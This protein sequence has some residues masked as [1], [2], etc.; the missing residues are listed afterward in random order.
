MLEADLGENVNIVLQTGGAFDWKDPRIDA[1]SCQRFLIQRGE[2]LLQEELALLNTTEPES[3]ADF[4]VWVRDNYPA[5]RYGLVLWNHGG[6]TIMGFGADQ[7]YPDDMMSLEEMGQALSE[8]GVPMDF[9][10][11]DACLM[12]TVETACML[13]PY[14]DYLIASEEMEPG[15]GWYYTDWLSLLGEN[16]GVSTEELGKKIVDDFVDGPDS[17]FWSD[18]T[19]SVIRLKEISRFYDI[20]CGYLEECRTELKTTGGYGRIA[21]ARSDT[22]SYGEGGFEQID[23]ADYVKLA[24]IEGGEEVLEGLSDIVAYNNSNIIGANGLAMYFPYDYPEYYQETM[25]SMEEIGIEGGGYQAF[26][27][28]F[29]NILVYGQETSESCPSVMA[30]ITGYEKEEDSGSGFLE[31][32][33]WY[34]PELGE[35]Y[36]DYQETLGADELYLEEKDGIFVLSLT[37]EE[38]ENITYME[39]QVYLEDGEGYMEL[40]CDNVGE[41]DGEGDLIVD[42]DY[43]WVALNGQVVPFYAEQEGTR[44]DGS[45]Y[46]YGYVPAELNG[47]EDIEILIYWDEEHE[48]GYVAGYRP[49]SG[50]GQAFPARNMLQFAEEDELAF[51]CDYYTYDGGYDASYYIGDSVV[52]DSRGLTVSYEEVEEYDAL[53][54]Y[55]LTDLYRNEYWTESVEISYE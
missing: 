53:I 54:C 7:Y 50:N 18:R 2:L 43:T 28:E 3:L 6:G 17:F 37:D 39:L 45:W 24:G 27:D 12:G 29:L 34:D 8:C 35:G 5:D 52:Y 44:I 38:W 10:G 41:F 47:E 33:S 40:G 26:F 25:Q 55:Y 19:L 21:A 32:A 1:D 46:T 22:R 42:F 30:A 14:A 11:F 20:L 49:N 13:E 15:S 31:W 23:I 16:P 9:V 51:Y 4:I 36:Q 48:G